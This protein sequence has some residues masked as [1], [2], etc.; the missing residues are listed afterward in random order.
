M[1][2]SPHIVKMCVCAVKAF[3]IYSPSNF[4]IYNAVL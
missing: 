2:M 3:K 4:K 1:H